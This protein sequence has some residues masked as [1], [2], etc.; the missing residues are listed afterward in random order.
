M[1]GKGLQ[2]LEN[3]R[4]TNSFFHEQAEQGRIH[5]RRV[6]DGWAGA[7]MQKLLAT[8]KWRNKRNFSDFFSRRIINIA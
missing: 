5:G 7:V 8:Q 1:Y 3:Q 2:G 4:A 6:T